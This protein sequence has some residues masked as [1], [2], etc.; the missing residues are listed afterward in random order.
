MAESQ[1]RPG[2]SRDT[3]RANDVEAQLHAALRA[4][5]LQ[6]PLTDDE[7]RQ[8]EIEL[9]GSGVEL[10][11]ALRDPDFLVKQ[12]DCETAS[13]S[14]QPDFTS[15]EQTVSNLARAAQEGGTISEEIEARM[16]QDRE[17]SERQTNAGK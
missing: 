11:A 8:A 16:R 13:E 6:I 10:P 2:T 5:G 9:V 14:I 3:A 7:V 17:Q 15:S 4:F 1:K 12:F